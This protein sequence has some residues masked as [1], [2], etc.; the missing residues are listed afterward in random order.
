MNYLYVYTADD[1]KFDR[2]DKMADVAKNLED[3]VFGVNDIESIVYL[4]EK[5]GFKAMNVDAVI[6]VL[7]ACTQDDVIYLCTPEDNTIVKASF[8]NVK[9]ICNE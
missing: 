2:L 5:Y 3:F 8:N 4:K 6:D 9:E 1:K 7:N